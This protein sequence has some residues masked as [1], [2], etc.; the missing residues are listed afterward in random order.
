MASNKMKKVLLMGKSNSG[1]TSMRSIIFANYLARNTMRLN[2][3][4]DVEHSTVRF[5]GNLVLNLWD[6]GG[7][8]A[9]F[10]NYFL[11]QRDHIF[12]NVEVLIYVF[13]IETPAS[14]LKEDFDNYQ[15]CIDSI[16]ENSPDAQ[17][18]ALVH[19]MD[20]VADEAK[21]KLFQERVAMIKDRSMGLRLT[22]FQTSIWDET[23]YKAWSAIVY[24]LIPN[25][26]ELAAKLSEFRRILDADEVVLF[27]RASFLV[28]SQ[29]THT[30]HRDVH[31]FEK[32]SNIIKQ[33][34]LSCS[35]TQAQL[36]SMKV[37]NST[38]TA[39]IEEF[40]SNTF[41]MVITSDRTVRK[42]SGCPPLLCCT[43]LFVFVAAHVTIHSP[44][45]S[46]EAA[47]LLNIRVGRK[48]FEKV[49]NNSTAVATKKGSA[50][51]SAKK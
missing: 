17:V 27:E 32:I 51:A 16:V 8:K 37:A 10:E 3:T 2:A 41:A 29:A 25:T 33:F 38:F 4:I 1:K 12:R 35:K 9:F 47:T 42:S 36:H 5:L 49:I 40:T 30:E 44:P 21:E 23:L 11:S 22:C 31:R 15:D 39:F 50:G 24:S 26:K 19:K 45:L 13:D 48:Y 34:K 43:V 14:E 7:Q 46:A 18:Y 20:L 6:C 28:V